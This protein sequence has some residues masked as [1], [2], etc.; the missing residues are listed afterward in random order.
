MLVKDTIY[1]ASAEGRV[2]AVEPESG[3]VRWKRDLE[4]A[5]S[6]GVGHHGDSIFVGP[7]KGW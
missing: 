4:L 7:P 2:M 1:V 3:R 6:G 5:L